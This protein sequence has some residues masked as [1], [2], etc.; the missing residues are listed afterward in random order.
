M[1]RRS[2]EFR[3]Q[4]DSTR[5][6]WGRGAGAPGS[7][8]Y[9][10][11]PRLWA[12]AFGAVVMGLAMCCAGASLDAQ[13]TEAA[14]DPVRPAAAEAPGSASPAPSAIPDYVIS[15]QDVLS[16]EV[17]EE[18]QFSR[19]C[20]VSPSG[21][22]ALPLLKPITAAGLSTNE[23]AAFIAHDL[24]DSGLLSR[25]VVTVT[26]KASPQSTVIVNG[27]VKNPQAV[28]LL[29]RAKLLQ[30]VS[31][32]G[33]LADDAGSTLT[34]NRGPAGLR[35]LAREG[36]PLTSPVNVEVKGLLDGTGSGADVDVFPG[37]RVTVPR[38]GL[39]YVLGEVVRPGGYNLRDAQEQISILKA[40]AI[41]GDV[42]SLAKAKKAVLI[43]KDPKAPGGREQIALNIPGIIAG[44]TPDQ[45]V[46]ADDVLYVPS[47]RAKR[48]LRG[49]LTVGQSSASG[50]TTGLIVYRR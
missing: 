28:P 31:Q 8:G 37:D 15:P 1:V 40:L 11:Y 25:P 36:K 43:R 34:V 21:T 44:R 14:P 3:T 4:T 32:A 39:F 26:L 17:F 48:T 9:Q 16:V 47:S 18:P 19:D 35:E 27:A 22:I 42:T 23:L 2:G 49:L 50:V 41:A 46:L 29:G 30:L 7:M 6:V 20:I 38:A 12:R 13:Q 45:Q 10:W 24:T 5:L 33:G